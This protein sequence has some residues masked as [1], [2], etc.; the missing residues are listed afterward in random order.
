MQTQTTFS[1]LGAS[2]NV[3]LPSD[4]AHDILRR[5]NYGNGD[6]TAS[7]GQFIGRLH[8]AMYVASADRSPTGTIRLVRMKRLHTLANRVQGLG[9]QVTWS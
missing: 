3:V 9:Q 2:G 5:M 4:A 1:A 6:S 8:S 7:G